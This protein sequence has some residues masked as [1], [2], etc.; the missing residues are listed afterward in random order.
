MKKVIA[1]VLTG[2]L[3]VGAGQAIKNSREGKLVEKTNKIKIFDFASGKVIEMD[4]YLKTEAELKKELP[5]DVCF[6]TRQKGTER[7]FSGKYLD[8]H[9]A[10]I[11]KCVACGIDLFS[12]DSKFESGTGWPSYCK[13]VSEL[14][15][16]EIADESYGMIRTEVTCARCGSHLGHVFAD[17]P[18]PTGKRFCIN[19]AALQFVSK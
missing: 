14:N 4:K 5:P 19:S 12:S 9:K 2:F 11:Y 3:L 13:P 1:L 15:I 7:A 10:G 18:K 17:G 16:K 6:I 8:N